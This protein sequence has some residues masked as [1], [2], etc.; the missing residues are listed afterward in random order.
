MASVLSMHQTVHSQPFSSVA[1][2]SLGP[3]DPINS[4]EC[5]FLHT[6]LHLPFPP[7]ILLLECFSY[8]ASYSRG[9]EC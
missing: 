9:L 5:H 4:G 3:W 1:L 6:Y 8:L 7:E 2:G